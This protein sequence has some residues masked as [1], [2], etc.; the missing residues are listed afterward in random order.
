MSK[1]FS[2]ITEMGETQNISEFHFS[3]KNNGNII[4]SIANAIRRIIGLDISTHAFFNIKFPKNT[5]DWDDERIEHQIKFIPLKNNFL[6][7]KDLNMIEVSLNCLNEKQSYRYV[8]SKELTVIDKETKE[9]IPIESI[10]L[11]DNLPL[12]LLGPKQEISSTFNIEYKTKRQSSS[13]HQPAMAGLDYVEDEKNQNND[14]NEILLNVCNESD[15]S[16]KEL[17]GLALDNIIDRIKNISNAIEKNDTTYVYVQNNKNNRISFVC[18]DEDH[19]IGS[20]I[21]EWNNRNDNTTVTGYREIT[22]KKTITFEYGIIE[23][24]NKTSE[25]IESM[26]EKSYMFQENDEI[27]N[28]TISSFINNLQNL[29]TY[30]K[31]LK[32]D[33]DKIKTKTISIQEYQKILENKR[34]ERMDR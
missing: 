30:I 23:N 24:M 31:D 12:F 8:F 26:V 7:D 18:I 16:S 11:Y 4:I 10:I 15:Y 6:K 29:E 19:T 33:F 14:P 25:K 1:H 3:I 17:I 13:V 27:K 21:T 2:D 34:L 22:D 9:D 20:L 32:K 5:S 28:K